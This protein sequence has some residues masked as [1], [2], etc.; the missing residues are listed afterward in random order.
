[1]KLYVKLLFLVGGGWVVG[2]WWVGGSE[3]NEINAILN[4]KLKLEL[5]EVG[6]EL[7]NICPLA[8]TIRNIFSTFVNSSSVWTTPYQPNHPIYLM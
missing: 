4:S 6:V 7:G 3:K 1:M 8:A 2:G 5:V